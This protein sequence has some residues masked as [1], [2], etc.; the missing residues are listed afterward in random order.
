VEN[1]S[2]PNGL[3]MVR[4]KKLI[5]VVVGGIVFCASLFLLSFTTT[6]TVDVAG[7]TQLELA[8]VV[9]GGADVIDVFPQDTEQATRSISPLS[10]LACEQY[11]RRPFAVM[12]SGDKIARPLA[13]VAQADMVIEMPVITGSIT[14]F[15][16][17]FL[18]NDPDTI[19]SVRSA[20]HDFIPL[21]AGLDAVLVHW[22]GSVFALEKLKE[23]IV[24]NIDALENPANAFYREKNAPPAPHNGFTSTERILVAMDRLQYRKE[25][26]FEGYRFFDDADVKNQKRE[27]SEKQLCALSPDGCAV[28][29]LHP[30]SYRV[31][32][33]YDAERN[34]YARER[35]GSPE[36]DYNTKSQVRASNIIVMIAGMRQIEGQYN[37]VDVEGEGKIL[38]FQNGRKIEGTWKKNA[39]DIKGKLYFLDA[40][41]YELALTP[42][43]TWIEIV[44][45]DQYV[46]S[47]FK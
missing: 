34:T 12:I 3:K 42:G 46:Q 4:Y 9:A 20:R 36:M 28:T 7:E 30:A 23:K 14:R 26:V 15:M 16:A 32:Y 5:V 17:I 25:S 40:L 13:G 44:E 38:L 6:K 1:S 21:A 11:R 33:R 37:D 35:G 43:Q 47:D 39:D 29:I 19:G 31:E 45:S 27:F 41:G 2:N 22:G 10:G 8:D 24:D 18:C